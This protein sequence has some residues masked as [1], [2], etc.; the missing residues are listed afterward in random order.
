MMVGNR[1]ASRSKGPCF[2][3]FYYYDKYF[4]GNKVVK[5]GEFSQGG[6]GRITTVRI[7]KNVSSKVSWGFAAA[8]I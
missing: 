5:S 4:E 1:A 6:N 8:S 3:N 2:L 7:S